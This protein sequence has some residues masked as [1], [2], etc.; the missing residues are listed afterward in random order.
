LRILGMWFSVKFSDMRA[1]IKALIGLQ[2]PFVRTP[3]APAKR[4]NSAEAWGIALRLTRFESFMAVVL[5]TGAV[6]MG[7]KALTAGDQTQGQVTGRLFLS[8]WLTYYSVIFAAAPIYAYKSFA[9][10]RTDAEM[11]ASPG[12]LVPA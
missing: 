1:A 6:L 9:T 10:L 4:P 7:I 12:P 11:A 2:I 5:V 8:F 3:K